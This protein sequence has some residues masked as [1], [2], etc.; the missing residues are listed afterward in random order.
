MS[1]VTSHDIITTLSTWHDY[2]ERRTPVMAPR[3][4]A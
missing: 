3:L 1:N 2:K 4:I